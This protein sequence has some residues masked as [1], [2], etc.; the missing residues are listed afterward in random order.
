MHVN[1]GLCSFKIVVLCYEQKG[2]FINSDVFIFKMF[3][4][5]PRQNSTNKEISSSYLSDTSLIDTGSIT[6]AV[7]FQLRDTPPYLM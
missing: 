2:A 3:L 4:R 1:R 5:K 7:K 6:F